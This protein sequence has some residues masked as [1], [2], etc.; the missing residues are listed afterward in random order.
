MSQSLWYLSGVVFR[1]QATLWSQT[2]EHDNLPAISAKFF[3]GFIPHGP[4]DKASAYGAEDSEVQ[5]LVWKSIVLHV[6]TFTVQRWKES[7]RKEMCAQKW[8]DLVH[9]MHVLCAPAATAVD[10]AQPKAVRTDI[11]CPL[12]YLDSI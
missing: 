3:L 10:T 9:A 6:C 5:P 4:M 12:R 1:C 11:A 8:G 7:H 2:A